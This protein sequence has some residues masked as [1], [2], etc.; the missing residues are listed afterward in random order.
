MALRPKK[1]A[2]L[3]LEERLIFEQPGQIKVGRVAPP[4]PVGHWSL[5]GGADAFTDP[6]P[7]D[8]QLPKLLNKHE[9]AQMESMNTDAL[10]TQITHEATKVKYIKTSFLFVFA[11]KPPR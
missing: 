4:P 7:I 10:V 6:W 8:V 1:A 3:I 9:R 5:P 2:K 11:M